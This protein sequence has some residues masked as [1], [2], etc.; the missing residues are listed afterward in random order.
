M[1]FGGGG[2]RSPVEIRGGGRCLFLRSASRKRGCTAGNVIGKGGRCGGRN[3]KSKRCH[4]TEIEKR[5]KR[6]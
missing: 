2:K 6:K 1:Q 3:F 4:V 5:G